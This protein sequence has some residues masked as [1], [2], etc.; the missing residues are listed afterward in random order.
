M[1][2]QTPPFLAVDPRT[3][4]VVD[5]AKRGTPDDRRVCQVEDLA[6]D[7]VAALP[8]AVRPLRIAAVPRADMQRDTEQGLDLDRERLATRL[9][10]MNACTLRV[11]RARSI[12]ELDARPAELLDTAVTPDTRRVVQSAITVR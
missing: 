5:D 8:L 1:F 4:D 12:R 6:L 2:E 11:P 7:P 9:S 10:Q 3:C